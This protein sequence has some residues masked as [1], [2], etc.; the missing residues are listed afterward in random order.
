MCLRRCS[1]H[2]R[3]SSGLADGSSE[4]RA[5]GRSASQGGGHGLLAGGSSWGQSKRSGLAWMTARGAHHSAHERLSEPGCL[6]MTWGRVGWWSLT[7][8]RR[9]RESA[10]HQWRVL[11]TSGLILR[12]WLPLRR[13]RRGGNR[14]RR[15]KHGRRRGRWG[16]DRLAAL[17]ARPTHPRHMSGNSELHSARSAFKLDYILIHPKLTKIPTTMDHPSHFDKLNF[18]HRPYF[19]IGQVLPVRHRPSAAESASESGLGLWFRKNPDEGMLLSPLPT[20]A[21]ETHRPTCG[22]EKAKRRGPP[23]VG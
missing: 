9:L 1:S 8:W 5:T 20:L 13:R 19:S 17:R 18:S 14:N 10:G 3:A 16:S 15:S 12:R 7:I 11:G 21:H 2:G 23:K 6:G 4:E 22:C